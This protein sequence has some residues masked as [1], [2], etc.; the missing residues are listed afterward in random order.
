MFL[1]WQG[2]ISPDIFLTV[3]SNVFVN[4]LNR[5]P[6]FQTQKFFPFVL[7]G[8]IRGEGLCFFRC[9]FELLQPWLS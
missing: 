6:W 9:L 2:E 5:N 1:S 3:S 7:Q 4:Y 8:R